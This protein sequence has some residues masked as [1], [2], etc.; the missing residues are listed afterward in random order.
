MTTRVP[1][2]TVSPLEPADLA[3]AVVLHE[4]LLP[5]GFFVDLGTRFMCRYYRGYIE[6][7]HGY[8]VVARSG[9]K[10]VGAL[11]GTVDHARHAAWTTRRLPALALTGGTALA[12]RPRMVKRFLLT[13]LG[14]Y[15]RAVGRRI[16]RL[17]AAGEAV[18]GD[19]SAQVAVLAH[20][21]VDPEHQGSGLGARLVEGFISRARAAGATRAELVTLAGTAGAGS[22]YAAHGWRRPGGAHQIDGRSYHTYILDL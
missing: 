2:T 11:V 21:F 12:L 13:R 16:W 6:S 10:V 18:A 5:H 4:R 7:P 17:C 15:A 8:G 22:F 20:V 3:A 14:R 9:D 19:T 1:P